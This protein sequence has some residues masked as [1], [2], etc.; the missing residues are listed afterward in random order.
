MKASLLALLLAISTLLTSAQEKSSE[1]VLMF[2]LANTNYFTRWERDITADTAS[3]K[4]SFGDIQLGVSYGKWKGS[5]MLYYGMNFGFGQ[6]KYD[7]RVNT[8]NFSLSPHIGLMK[9]YSLGGPLYYM[10]SGEAYIGINRYNNYDQ[11][12]NKVDHSNRYSGG[13][14]A[15]PFTI[16]VEASKKWSMLLSIGSMYADYSTSKSDGFNNTEYRSSSFS[17]GASLN[18]F[19]LRVLVGI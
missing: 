11:N 6:Q 9:R 18:T 1:P 13:I 12:G 7:A 3:G 19:R 8:R 17:A 2:S 15:T 14:N 10:P 16:G 5:R 4:L